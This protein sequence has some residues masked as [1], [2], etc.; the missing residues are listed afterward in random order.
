MREGLE[1]QRAWPSD[2][3]NRRDTLVNAEEEK[4]MKTSRVGQ[5]QLSAAVAVDISHWTTKNA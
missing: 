2:Q 3:E 5:S 1:V 4:N